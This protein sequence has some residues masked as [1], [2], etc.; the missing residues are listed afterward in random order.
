MD[1]C[2]VAVTTF[3]VNQEQIL[4]HPTHTIKNN[5]AGTIRYIQVISVELIGT[6]SNLVILR[7][8]INLNSM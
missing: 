8:I 1:L 6:A 4:C 3:S 7:T 5:E 2:S